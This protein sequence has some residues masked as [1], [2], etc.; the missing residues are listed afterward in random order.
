MPGYETK[1]PP[2]VRAENDEKVAGYDREISE[3]VKQLT[4]LEKFL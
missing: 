3:T 4:I 2:N 1:V